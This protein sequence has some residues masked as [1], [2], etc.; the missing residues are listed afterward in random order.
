[1]DF[2][3]THYF[4]PLFYLACGS[5]CVAS[6]IAAIVQAMIGGHAIGMIAGWTASAVLLMIPGLLGRLRVVVGDDVLRIRIGWTPLFDGC[7][8]L[9]DVTDLRLCLDGQ[10]HD[11]VG[12]GMRF[13]ANGLRCYSTRGRRFTEFRFANRRYMIAA[14]DPAAL[15][16][17]ILRV[18]MEPV[19][20]APQPVPLRRSPRRRW[21]AP[22]TWA[23]IRPQ[24]V[25]SKEAST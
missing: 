7:F 12:W 18:P 15:K 6:A 13:G 9:D 14:R 5:L 25:R 17:A 10:E 11:T 3:E 21:L 16:A 22:N 20:D 2:R 24:D 8:N 23:M 1:M 4:H 19:E